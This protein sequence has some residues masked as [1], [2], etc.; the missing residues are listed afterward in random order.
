MLELVLTHKGFLST[1]SKDTRDKLNKV[2]RELLDLEN[3]PYKAKLS[4]LEEDRPKAIRYLSR[5][6][7]QL[8]LGDKKAQV[9]DRAQ[10]ILESSKGTLDTGRKPGPQRAKFSWLR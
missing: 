6:I 2:Y 8:Q 9:T 3:F 10:C 1:P 5:A 4:K 7:G